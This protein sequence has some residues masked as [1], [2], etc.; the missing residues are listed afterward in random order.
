MGKSKEIK[1][2]FISKA[3]KGRISKNQ[4]KSLIKYSFDKEDRKYILSKLNKKYWDI[5]YNNPFPETE[6]DIALEESVFIDPPNLV[7]ELEWFFE[8]FYHYENNLFEY[9]EIKKNIEI[10][11]LLGNT[12]K[13]DGLLNEGL[14]KLNTSLY[15]III[16]MYLNELEN[17]S[18]ENENLIK[19]ISKDAKTSKLPLIVE[20]ARFRIEKEI[21]PWQYDSTLEHHKAFYSNN[22]NHI[23][24][25]V[26]FKFSPL[27]YNYELHG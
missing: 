26:V 19:L 10:Q 25:Y 18:K 22:L 14:S 15:L 23:Q 8:I 11:I 5:A 17:K 3:L 12:I 6:Q 21:L 4:F 20:F 13:L 7:T 2:V 16:E 9:Y 1:R 24:D 27:Y